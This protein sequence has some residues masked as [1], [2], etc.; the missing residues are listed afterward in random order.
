MNGSVGRPMM[1]GKVAEAKKAAGCF[2]PLALHSIELDPWVNP[3]R[4]FAGTELEVEGLMC[5]KGGTWH[6]SGKVAKVKFAGGEGRFG[7]SLRLL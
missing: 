7:V 2:K 5:S 1:K 3:T 6:S 4:R